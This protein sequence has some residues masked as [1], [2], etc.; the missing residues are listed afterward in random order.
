MKM[1]VYLLTGILILSL[2]GCASW[3]GISLTGD[4]QTSGSESSLANSHWR[5][6]SYG[7]SGSESPVL[8]GTDFTLQFE[9]SSQAGG[10]T[11][12]N[13]FGAR[14]EVSAGGRISI[15]EITSTLMACNE[16]ALVEQESQVLDA[17]RSAESF[18]LNGESLSIHYKGGVL[19]FS[20]IASNPPNTVHF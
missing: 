8:E 1:T 12:C 11:G 18:E 4:K 15:T 10:N 9:D 17:L 16:E 13:T 20:R 6:V 19:I 14:Y 2:I 5:L 3:P 7:E